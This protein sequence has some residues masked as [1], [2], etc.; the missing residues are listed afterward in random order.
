MFKLGLDYPQHRYSAYMAARRVNPKS[1][2]N[3]SNPPTPRFSLAKAAHYSL[4][5]HREETANSLSAAVFVLM[6]FSH[7]TLE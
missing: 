2:S 7:K 5:K 1:I 3:P 6:F 4:V